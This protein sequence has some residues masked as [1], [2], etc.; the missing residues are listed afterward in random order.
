MEN[1]KIEKMISS[2]QELPEE[3]Q[4]YILGISQALL[5]AQEHFS[6]R[7]TA[8]ENKPYSEFD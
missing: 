8:A 1:E 3:S 5:F 7:K 2:F 6:E 4:S